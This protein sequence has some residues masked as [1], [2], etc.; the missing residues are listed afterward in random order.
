M[1]NA[2]GT[3]LIKPDAP[4]RVSSQASFVFSHKRRRTS[5]YFTLAEKLLKKA[6]I[7]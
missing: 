2:D 1:G 4:R 6:T 3:R 7:S 5:F